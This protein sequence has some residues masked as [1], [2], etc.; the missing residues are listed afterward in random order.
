MRTPVV[1]TLRVG[2]HV[3]TLCVP[4]GTCRD[5][6]SPAARE[7]RDGLL[8]LG[9]ALSLGVLLLVVA[10]VYMV[11]LGLVNSALETILLSGLYLYA[12]QGE[13]PAGMDRSV[14]Q[15]AFAAK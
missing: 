4:D 7:N 3:R 9:T 5:R 13:V 12:T 14:V 1:S 6:N 2:T 10:V 11:A 15:G 8:L